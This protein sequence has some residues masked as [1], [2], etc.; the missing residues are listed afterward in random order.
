MGGLILLTERIISSLLGSVHNH[1]VFLTF[2][3]LDMNMYVVVVVAI[4]PV[5]KFRGSLYVVVTAC[6]LHVGW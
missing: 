2:V 4:I 3:A 5:A 6:Y 1:F